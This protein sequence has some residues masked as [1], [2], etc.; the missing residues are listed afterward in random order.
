MRIVA[1]IVIAVLLAP[2]A[3]VAGPLLESAIRKATVIRPTIVE[4]PM[5]CAEATATGQD[6]ADQ[7]EGS[8]GYLVGGIF[9]PVIMPLIAMASRPTAPAAAITNLDDAD[10]ACFQDGYGDRGRSK[11]VRA[12][13]IG[14]GIGIALGVV[15]VAAAAAQAPY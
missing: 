15:L 2:S 6:L 8:G 11:K 10:V 4:Q 5:G 13:W 1:A 3:A 14:S 7:R 12:G 9:I